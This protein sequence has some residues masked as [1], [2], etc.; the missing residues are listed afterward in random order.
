[1]TPMA[2]YKVKREAGGASKMALR[3]KVPVTEPRDMN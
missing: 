1:M 3:V 2:K